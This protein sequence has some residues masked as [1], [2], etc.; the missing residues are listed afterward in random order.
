MGYTIDKLTSCFRAAEENLTVFF[1]FDK[2]PAG[3]GDDWT[4]QVGTGYAWLHLAWGSGVRNFTANL[5]VASRTS[6]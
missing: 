4:I 6:I 1:D 5:P 3:L 2:Y